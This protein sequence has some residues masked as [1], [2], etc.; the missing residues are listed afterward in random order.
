MF[1]WKWLLCTGSHLVAVGGDD[2]R[3]VFIFSFLRRTSAVKV[4][5]DNIIGSAIKDSTTES[6]VQQPNFSSP[7]LIFSIAMQVWSLFPFIWSTSHLL[8]Q[9]ADVFCVQFNVFSGNDGAGKF[10]AVGDKVVKS[11][12]VM[13]RSCSKGIFGGNGVLQSALCLTF[14]SSPAFVITGMADGDIYF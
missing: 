11:S 1:L 10:W 6:P 7:L 2:N 12:D 13:A 8:F 5:K 14:S 3:T 9:P 4:Y